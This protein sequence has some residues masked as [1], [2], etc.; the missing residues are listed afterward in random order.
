MSL[1]KTNQPQQA[2]NNITVTNKTRLYNIIHYEFKSMRIRTKINQRV[3]LLNY[4]ALYYMLVKSGFR[5]V[6]KRLI[7]E[8]GRSFV[9]SLFL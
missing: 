1:N 3:R 4:S 5:M 9:A 6:I 2:Y 7:Q 8:L